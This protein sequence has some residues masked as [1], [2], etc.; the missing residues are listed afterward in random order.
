MHPSKVKET[1]AFLARRIFPDGSL[2]P[3]FALWNHLPEELAFDIQPPSKHSP[4]D[5]LAI[6]SELV[7]EPND[8]PTSAYEEKE[9][10]LSF[11]REFFSCAS[12]RIKYRMHYP[13]AGEGHSLSEPVTFPSRDGRRVLLAR[14]PLGS[15]RMYASFSGNDGITWTP[16]RPTNIPDSPSRTTSVVLEDGT[17]LLIGNQV[18]PRFEDADRRHYIRDPLTVSVS[19]DGLSFTQ[20]YALRHGAPE[21]RIGGVGG[22]G[23]GF[24][25]P[26]A[27]VKSGIL[28][29]LYS[30]GKED[31]EFLSVP[32]EE[33][34][35]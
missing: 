17:V 12:E 16:A 31:I 13:H 18:A 24:Q 27:I 15:H 32:L 9:Y 4:D 3:I 25:Y 21:L 14:D 26:G 19:P 33:I 7:S 6:I 20:V 22:R 10:I 1:F 28:H 30:V 11:C 29:V 2:G 35:G 5:I 23:P 8:L 34:V